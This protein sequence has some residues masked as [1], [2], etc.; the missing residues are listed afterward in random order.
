M[1]GEAAC[2]AR[3]GHLGR[4]VVGGDI[5]P[6]GHQLPVL[7]VVAVLAP[8]VEE[9]R[10]VRVL[11]GLGDVQ[12]A[13]A[14]SRQR[15]GQRARQRHVVEG[16]PRAQRL[17]VA[18]HR[19]QQA[20]RRQQ[21]VADL[22]R[23]VGTEVEE[24]E[25][26]AARDAQA[27][28]AE[29]DRRDELVGKSLGVARL[30]CGRRRDRPLPHAVDQRRARELGALGAMVAIHRVVAPDDGRDDRA[31]ARP[32][33]LEPAEQAGRL[34]GRD[35]AAVRER[36]HRDARHARRERAAHDRAQVVDVRMHAAVGDEPGHV[37]HAAAGLGGR[38]R[39]LQRG[40]LGQRAVGHRIADAHEI[41]RDDPPRADVEMAD[42]GVAHLPFGQAHRA[43]GCDQRRVR[44]A[45]PERVEDRRARRAAR[46]CR[47]L[48]AHTRS[49]RG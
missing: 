26:I 15:V 44:P 7:A 4:V 24:H 45:L 1:L 6:R 43:P 5:A 13:Q 11:L 31:R 21:R 48:R 27:G 22:P 34:M 28:V 12:L 20:E 42:L 38:E 23:A 37:Q 16:D 36:M 18:R 3:G 33:R 29:D 14:G 46:R 8:A 9:V 32:L 10:H 17:V 47:G 41:L 19:H 35:V 40:V 49:R 39:S 25:G 30:D 2:D